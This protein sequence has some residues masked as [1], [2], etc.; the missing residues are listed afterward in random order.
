MR[1]DRRQP[2][3]P[4]P[5]L[6]QRIN[7]IWWASDVERNKEWSW[8]R[9]FKRNPF[10][11]FCMVI[12]GI[13]HKERDVY[14]SVS[15]NTYAPDGGYNEGY[16]I[17]VDKPGKKYKFKSHRGDKIEW[18]V[19]WKTSGGFTITRRPANTPNAAEHP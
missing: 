11:N 3:R 16:S 18:C 14:Y 4:A 5:T 1:F 15:P 8:W 9:W 10:N 7:P 2:N 6:R 12:I 17:R 13:A 19:G